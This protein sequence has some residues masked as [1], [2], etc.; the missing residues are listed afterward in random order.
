MRRVSLIRTPANPKNRPPTGRAGR[1]PERVREHLTD[2]LTDQ[3]ADQLTNQLTDQVGHYIHESETPGA[4]K[5]HARTFAT[6][7]LERSQGGTVGTGG[8]RR[9]RVATRTGTPTPPSPGPAGTP[10]P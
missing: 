8:G 3:L 1:N 10:R 5:Q 2:Q 6:A 4:V 7:E 9:G